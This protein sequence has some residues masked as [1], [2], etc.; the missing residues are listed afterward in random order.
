MHLLISE[1]YNQSI[2][3]TLRTFSKNNKYKYYRKSSSI[4][5]EL[6]I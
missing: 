3:Q 1:G 2:L 5:N 6:T 4:P